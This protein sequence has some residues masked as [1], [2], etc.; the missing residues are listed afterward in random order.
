[1]SFKFTTNI[2]IFFLNIIA[3]GSFKTIYFLSDILFFVIYHIVGYR[4][5]VV[6]ENLRKAFPEKNENERRKIT[7]RYYHHLADLILETVKMRT[8]TQN[9]YE[10]RMELHNMEL[11]EAYYNQGKSVVILAMHYNN[12]EWGNYLGS[13]TKHR[14][15]AV[16]KPLHDKVFDKYLNKNR[17]RMGA[18]LIQTSQ[19]LRT[20]KEANN[21]KELLLVWLAADQTPP[22]FHKMWMTFLN[23]EAMFYPGPA[24]IPKRFNQPVVFQK[25]IKKSRGR[26]ASYFETLI[27]SP[28]QKTESE[29]LKLY[30][31][32]MEK[33]IR[34]QPEYYLWSHKRWKHQRPEGVALHG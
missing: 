18:D 27:E 1:M 28:A 21:K 9:D 6:V 30:I 8:M 26:Y 2:G 19:V 12:W 7:R 24:T 10:K 15:I 3:R 14:G 29:I 20:I 17:G 22:V 25:I 4:K 34:E 5:K 13:K 23:R 16:Y 11:F 33:T 31:E 32:K